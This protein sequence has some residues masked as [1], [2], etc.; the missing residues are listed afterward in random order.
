MASGTR[1]IGSDAQ[2]AVKFVFHQFCATAGV[3]AGNSRRFSETIDAYNQAFQFG[4]ADYEAWINIGDA[5]FFLRNRSDQSNRAYAEAVRLGR[6]EIV[7]RSRAG[8]SINATIPAN[9]AA[10]F[11]KLGLPDSAR[12]YLDRALATGG[13]NYIVQ[14]CAALTRW[15]LDQRD[16]A[17]QWLEKSVQRGTRLRG[18]AT[19]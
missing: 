10:V 15:Q 18:Y 19:R 11:P 13:Q 1:Q 16:E 7:S 17:I 4:L 9:L 14:Y 6:E 12:V 2:D 8:G 5:Y 3:H